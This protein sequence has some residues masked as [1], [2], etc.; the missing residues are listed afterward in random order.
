MQVVLL[1]VQIPC[2]LVAWGFK[3][4]P[5]ATSSCH[6]AKELMQAKAWILWDGSKI[7]SC[8]LALVDIVLVDCYL[9]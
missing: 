8:S 3:T 6:L 2:I 4:Y 1:M 7:I 9:D 5:I